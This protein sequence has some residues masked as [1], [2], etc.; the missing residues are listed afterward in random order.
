MLKVLGW[1]ERDTLKLLLG[2]NLARH[3][4]VTTPFVEFYRGKAYATNVTVL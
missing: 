4:H 2:Y 3:Q 1:Q